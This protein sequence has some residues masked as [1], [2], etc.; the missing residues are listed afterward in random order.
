MVIHP[1]GVLPIS[2]G[3]EEKDAVAPEAPYVP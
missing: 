3:T 2:D 1:E